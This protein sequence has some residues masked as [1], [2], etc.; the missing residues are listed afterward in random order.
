M[1][2]GLWVEKRRGRALVDVQLSE[3][4]DHAFY[5]STAQ[6]M[7]QAGMS[8]PASATCHARMLVVHAIAPP[9]LRGILLS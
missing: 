5:A 3:S 7:L 9:Q 8:L 6:Y 2:G 4:Y 1:F